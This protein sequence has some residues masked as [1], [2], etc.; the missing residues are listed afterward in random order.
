MSV[1][2]LP[3]LY[4]RATAAAAEADLS[5][6]QSTETPGMLTSTGRCDPEVTRPAP[7]IPTFTL[8]QFLCAGWVAKASADTIYDRAGPDPSPS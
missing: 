4:E 1:Y 6:I 2:V 3:I 5:Q 8:D 7:M